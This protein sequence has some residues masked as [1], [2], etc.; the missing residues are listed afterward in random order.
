MNRSLIS[1]RKAIANNLRHFRKKNKMTQ[2]EFAEELNKLLHTEYK[3]NAI[4]AWE[5]GK[6]SINSD[7]MPLIAQILHCSL[8]DL[9]ALSPNEM[10]QKSELTGIFD[11]LDSQEREAVEEYARYLLWKRRER[12]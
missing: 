12:E 10:R 2:G 5:N 6:N 3:S 7:Y 8:R 11:L 1:F 4:S 9:Y